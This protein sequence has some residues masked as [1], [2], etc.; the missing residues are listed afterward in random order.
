M[1]ICSQDLGQESDRVALNCTISAC[2]AA[3]RWQEA[4][5]FIPW[6]HKTN[7][8]EPSLP[9]IWSPKNIDHIVIV[10]SCS[11]NKTIYHIIV[12][13]SINH[14]HINHSSYIITSPNNT[15]FIIQA[16]SL[17]SKDVDCVSFAA[18]LGACGAHWPRA[19]QLLGRAEERV[20][21]DVPW[22]WIPGGWCLYVYIVDIG[23]HTFRYIYICIC[24]RIFTYI[25][26]HRYKWIN[27]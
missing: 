7:P 22:R 4:R 10:D 24:T 5:P 3:A 26:T 19:L 14:S 17:L 15:N 27:K 11:N 25:Y 12:I 2:S 20:E 23:V 18:A 6:A 21:L 16:I 9:D 1:F 8:M 13:Y